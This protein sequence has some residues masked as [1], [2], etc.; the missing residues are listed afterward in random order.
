MLK[1]LTNIWELQPSHLSK[2]LA[3]YVV[4]NHRPGLP[5]PHFINMYPITLRLHV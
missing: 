4:A 1:Y 5:Y 3:V 2:I